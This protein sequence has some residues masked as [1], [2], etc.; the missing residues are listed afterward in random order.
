MSLQFTGFNTIAYD[1]VSQQRMGAATSFY[2]TFQQL[3]LSM[4]ICAGAAA[5]AGRDGAARP[6]RAA[7]S[8]FHRRLL[9]SGGGVADRH[10]LEPRASPMK[11][12]R[13]ISGHT[14]RTFRPG[15]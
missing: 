13:E 6:S 14:P 2:T 11:P 15:R 7:I 8:R 5:L 1:E 4:G 12:A 10:H 9:D 3:M